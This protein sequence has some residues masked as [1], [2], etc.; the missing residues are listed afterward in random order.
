MRAKMFQTS[1][2]PVVRRGP[3]LPKTFLNA[4]SHASK[5]G[6]VE[7]MLFPGSSAFLRSR[8]HGQ[9][10]HTAVSRSAMSWK[11]LGRV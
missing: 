9:S 2:T 10:S 3:S 7:R 6:W 11:T 5:K 4:R 8:S 1:R